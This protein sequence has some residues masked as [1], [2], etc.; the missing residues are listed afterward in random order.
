MIR[1]Q[2][3]VILAPG[4][5][6]LLGQHHMSYL[7]AQIGHLPLLVVNA[8]IVEPE[9]KLLEGVGLLAGEPAVLHHLVEHYI[10]P[11]T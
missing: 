4:P 5:D 10:T 8:V 7:L 3:A 6:G 1:R 2:A 9:R 11:S